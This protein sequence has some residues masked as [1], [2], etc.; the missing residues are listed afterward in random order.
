MKNYRK[1]KYFGKLKRLEGNLMDGKFS[2]LENKQT[3]SNKDIE[4]NLLKII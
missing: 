3:F 2:N 4:G 1:A